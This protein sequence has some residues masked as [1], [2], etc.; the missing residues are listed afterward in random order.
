MVRIQMWCVVSLSCE[1]GWASRGYG[2]RYSDDLHGI[3]RWAL[4]FI[5]FWEYALMY[6]SFHNSIQGAYGVTQVH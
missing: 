6:S 4:H 2:S 1:R 5:S 3:N